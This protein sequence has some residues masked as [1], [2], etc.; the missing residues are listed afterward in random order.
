MEA[1]AQTR[2]CLGCCQVQK[3]QEGGGLAG[4]AASGRPVRSRKGEGSFVQLPWLCA[5]VGRLA[6]GL[7]G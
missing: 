4:K 5:E 3:E 7:P 2:L 6:K 1:H